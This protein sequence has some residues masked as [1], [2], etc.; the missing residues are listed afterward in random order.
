MSDLVAELAAV[1]WQVHHPLGARGVGAPLRV[2][3]RL[4]AARDRLRLAPPSL[5][6]RNPVELK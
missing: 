4:L 3:L 1:E 2:P 5:G 6:I